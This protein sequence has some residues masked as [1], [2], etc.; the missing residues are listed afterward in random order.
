[1]ENKFAVIETDA[2]PV[3]VVRTIISVDKLPQVIG[4]AYMEIMAYLGELKE[5]PA[6]MPFVAYYNMDMEK[7]DVAIGF[8][9]AKALPGRGEIIAGIIPAGKKATAMYKGPYKEMAP[10]YEELTKWMQDNGHQPSGVV[11]EFYYN[12]PMEVAESELLTKIVFLLK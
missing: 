9:V 11:Y 6:D 1:M 5:Q 10:I 4:K 3:L 2:Q 7:L 12:S 8:P